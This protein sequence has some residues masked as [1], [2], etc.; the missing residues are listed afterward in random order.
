MFTTLGNNLSG[1]GTGYPSGGPGDLTNT[2]AKLGPLQDN[3]GTTFTHALLTG[4][5]AI[6]GG[7]DSAAP[8]TDQRGT[9]QPQDSASDI[10]AFELVPG[11]SVPGVNRRV[12]STLVSQAS[13]STGVVEGRTFQM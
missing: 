6:D 4:S 3:G 11:T 5:P 2:N 9:S 8:A 7:N 12:L 1:V 13:A 10:G